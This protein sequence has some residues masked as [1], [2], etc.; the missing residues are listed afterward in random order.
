M[1]NISVNKKRAWKL[2]IELD[3]H[4]TKYI[5]VWNHIEDTLLSRSDMAEQAHH[6]DTKSK[7]LN[8]MMTSL[9]TRE[10]FSDFERKA[11]N[12]LLHRSENVMVGFWKIKFKPFGKGKSGK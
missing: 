12:N 4:I 5:A 10:S 6:I 2:A 7:E 11:I 1:S 9:V 8:I 3:D